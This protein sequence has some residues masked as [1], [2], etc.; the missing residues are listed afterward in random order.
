MSGNNFCHRLSGMTGTKRSGSLLNDLFGDHGMTALLGV[1]Q[2]RHASHITDKFRDLLH[3]LFCLMSPGG[4][5]VSHYIQLGL[6]FTLTEQHGTI[7]ILQQ[8]FWQRVQCVSPVDIG[9]R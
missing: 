2:D 4:G 8:V 1:A 7:H 5:D 6:V 9:C 3:G